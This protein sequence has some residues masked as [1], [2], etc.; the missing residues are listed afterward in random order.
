MEEQASYNDFP[1]NSDGNLAFTDFTYSITSEPLSNVRRFTIPIGKIKDK[2]FMSIMAQVRHGNYA[3]FKQRAWVSGRLLG[4][5]E[6]GQGFIHE[7]ELC[8][9]APT[10]LP[11]ENPAAPAPQPAP[12]DKE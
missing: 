11:A 2:K 4:N 12:T 3:D 6:K 10:D 1:M 5:T 8:K 7:V 9:T